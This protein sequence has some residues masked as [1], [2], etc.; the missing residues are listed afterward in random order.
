ML[1]VAYG[2]EAYKLDLLKETELKGLN[3]FSRKSFQG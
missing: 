1:Q 2:L 3:E